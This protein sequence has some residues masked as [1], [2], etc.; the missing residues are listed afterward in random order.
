MVMQS[1]V[2][3]EDSCFGDVETAQDH[4]PSLRTYDK[5]LQAWRQHMNSYTEVYKKHHVTFVPLPI[6]SNICIHS[7][8]EGWR[9]WGCQRDWKILLRQ[10]DWQYGGIIIINVSRQKCAV[11]FPGEPVYF[12][13]SVT[14]SLSFLVKF[15]SVVGI[16]M[17]TVQN[18]N[19]EYALV[20]VSKFRPHGDAH[21]AK[22]RRAMEKQ[23]E[24]ITKGV[25]DCYNDM[26]FEL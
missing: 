24:C 13:A 12:G 6:L 14:A 20:H 26:S 5:L 8:H 1:A 22:L 23:A 19:D 18:Y 21:I 4:E 10:L 9:Q 17:H 3:Y 25:T 11:Y 16:F 7:A 15:E 2:D